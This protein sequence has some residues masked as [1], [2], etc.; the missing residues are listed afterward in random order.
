[1][2]TFQFRLRPVLE[3]AQRREQQRQLELAHL[4]TELEAHEELL[5]ALRDE[6]SVWL[7]QL[8]EC[9]QRSFEIE[10]VR[11]RRI[12]LDNLSAAID[13]QSA[14]V[15]DM[16]QRVEEAQ[17]WLTGRP[18]VVCVEPVTGNGEGDLQVTFAGDD[19][20]LARLLSELVGAGFPVALFHEETGDLEDVFMRLTKGIVS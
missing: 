16:H 20:A 14:V 17:A 10:E 12:H 13:D 2:R 4:Q 1:M 19:E 18:E 9:Q 15:R 5:R 11:R 7:C 8:L 6:R 3:R